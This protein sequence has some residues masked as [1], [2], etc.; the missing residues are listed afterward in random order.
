MIFS[1]RVFCFDAEWPRREGPGVKILNSIYLPRGHWSIRI[2]G[3]I[4]HAKIS[5]IIVCQSGQI[6]AQ[7]AAPGICEADVKF[8]FENLCFDDD[9]QVFVDGELPEFFDTDRLD[10]FQLEARWVRLVS[11]SP[12]IVLNDI[13][14]TR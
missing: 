4:D 3:K 12:P 14:A 7:F 9:I 1:E 5:D 2:V 11:K 8:S 13:K 6:I 10:C